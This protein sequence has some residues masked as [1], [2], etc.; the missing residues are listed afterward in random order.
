MFFYSV[1]R[2]VPYIAAAVIAVIVLA[3]LAAGGQGG[4]KGGGPVLALKKFSLNE[5][6]A[7][8]LR[9]EGRT[10][11][12]FGWILSR[13]GIDPVTSLGCNRQAIKFEET[14]IRFGKKTLSIPLVAVTAV[15]S[16]V[17]KPFNVLV[18][19]I[20]CALGGIIGSIII[21]HVAL[22]VIGVLAGA[23]FIVLYIFR[24]TMMIGIYNGGDK[25]AAV[26]CMKKS[27]IENLSIDEQKCEAA[28]EAL[29]R[30]VLRIHYTL[31]MSGSAAP[32]PGAAS[33]VVR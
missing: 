3:V 14:S 22:F 27:M 29:N 30:A 9:I 33:Q 2:F 15:H 10:A 23:L 16:G 24:K 18:L 31:A 12:L 19:G 8:F 26:I 21:N 6:E 25:P 11:G 20:V 28:A 32:R 5:K 13:C 7:E 1:M 4:V 17:N